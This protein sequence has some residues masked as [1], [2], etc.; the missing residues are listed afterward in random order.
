MI[1]D[2]ETRGVI[3][4][5]DKKCI[6][7]GHDNYHMVMCTVEEKSKFKIKAYRHFKNITDY[8]NTDRLRITEQVK[9]LYGIDG[10]LYNAEKMGKLIGVKIKAYYEIEE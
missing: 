8:I 7:R 9:Q 1:L 5:P 2:K 4:T 10:N 6:L 3:M